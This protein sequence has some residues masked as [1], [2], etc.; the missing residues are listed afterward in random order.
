MQYQQSI[1]KNQM[2]ELNHF[3]LDVGKNGIFNLKTW[4]K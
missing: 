1:H 2:Y 3:I 4:S